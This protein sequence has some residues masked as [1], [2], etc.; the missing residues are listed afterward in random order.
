M[1]KIIGVIGTVAAGKD[2]VADYIGKK[3][4][5]QVYQISKAIKDEAKNR[6]QG[7]NR[8]TL[9]KL[10]T[11][12]SKK[13][14]SDYLARHFLD[15][16]DKT[17]VITGMREVGQLDFLKNKS[18]FILI[19]IDADPQIRFE[20]AIK[21]GKAGEAKDVEEFVSREK[22]ENSGDHAQR[23]F[24]CMP[25]ADYTITNNGTIEELHQKVDKI[26]NQIMSN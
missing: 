13:H 2:T 11:E 15:Y 25:L 17:L 21:R 23:L 6:S 5:C 14:G 9:I 4:N 16:P 19:A 18:N 8:D 1:K 20:R 10:G 22:K 24:E 3:L 12:L 7:T 26:L